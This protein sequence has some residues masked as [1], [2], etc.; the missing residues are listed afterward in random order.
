MAA[1]G[2]GEDKAKDF[3]ENLESVSKASTFLISGL[4][5]YYF[6]KPSEGS[7]ISRETSVEQGREAGA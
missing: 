3:S 5:T 2:I 4:L 1:M 6:A 7:G